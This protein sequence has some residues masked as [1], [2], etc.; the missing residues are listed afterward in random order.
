MSKRGV[1]GKNFFFLLSCL[2]LASFVLLTI[3]LKR[4]QESL[5]FEAFVSRVFAPFQSMGTDVVASV[6]GLW[7]RYIYLV[8]ASEENQQLKHD[9]DRLLMEK[10]RLREQVARQVRLLQLT[11]MDQSPE[12]PFV[13]ASVIGR[14][15]TQWSKVI[16]IDKG[17]D[18]EVRENLP[19]VTDAGILGHTIQSTQSSSK[20]LLITDSRSSVDALFQE[21]RVT[22]V[23]VGT[24]QNFCDMKYV[25]QTADVKVGDPVLSS[26]LGGIFPKGLMIGTIA[27][28]TRSHQGLFQDIRLSPSA[29]ITRLEEV[30]V[31]RP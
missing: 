13:V 4:G 2:F 3:N 17:I 22:G 11:G 5:F 24:G 18:D 20:V 9:V 30:L 25:P 8:G 19:V 7:G 6:S 1:T 29:E 16:V 31:L 26:G 12:T 14:D 21:S 28:V 15:A 10:N 27:E 23:V